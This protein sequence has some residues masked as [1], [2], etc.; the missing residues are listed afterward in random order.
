MSDYFYDLIQ[1][2]KNNLYDLVID[3]F[4]LWT[5]VKGLWL[6]WLFLKPQLC[7]WVVVIHALFIKC[8]MVTLPT[9]KCCPRQDVVDIKMLSMPRF[10]LCPDVAHAQMLFIPRCCKH[11]DIFHTQMKCCPHPDVAQ[12]RCVLQSDV[13]NTLMLS[14]PRCCLHPNVLYIQILPV[15]RCCLHPDVSTF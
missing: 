11:C 13:V 7:R 2:E 15:P 4:A 5:I 8:R 6:F 1:C 3:V 9:P 12:P 10:C 14:M